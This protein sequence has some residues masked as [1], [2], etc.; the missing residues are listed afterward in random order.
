[1]RLVLE[2]IKIFGPI[3]NC[4]LIWD[5][6]LEIHLSFFLQS[7]SALAIGASKLGQSMSEAGKKVGEVA[8]QKIGEVYKQNPDQGLKQEQ[9]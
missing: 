9:K 2:K 3:K 8:S 1:M 7:W 5:T 4:H 6:T